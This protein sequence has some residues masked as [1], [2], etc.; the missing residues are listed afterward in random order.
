MCLAGRDL[1]EPR[2]SPDGGLVGFVARWGSSAAI[3]TVPIDGGPERIV[4]TQPQPAPGRGL[5]GGC[6]EWVPDG[7]GIVYC[8]RDGNLWLQPVPG[9]AARR[10]SEIE[11][12]RVI[13]APSLAPDGSFV[14]AVV[15]QAELW[16][17]YIDGKRCTRT[18]R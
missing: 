15:D 8:G 9:G 5:N 7:S 13:E 3:C 10:I 17:W 14:V 4:T 1:T 11:L 18:T 2:P 12:D 6:F 16:R